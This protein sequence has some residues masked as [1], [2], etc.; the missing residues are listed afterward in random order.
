MKFSRVAVQ[1]IDGEETRVVIVQP[2]NHRVIDAKK[3]YALALQR[4][5]A[6]VD[7]SRRVAHAT[8]NDMT[9]AISL[10]DF[11]RDAAEVALSAADDASSPLEEAVFRAAIKP[12]VIRD[13]LT[14]NGHIKSFFGN[15][16]KKTP[17][18][19]VYER[20]GYFKG[21]TSTIFGT[22]ETI[23]FPSM[24]EKLDY[25]LEIGYIISKFG[26]SIEPENAF[27]HLFGL[28]IFNDWSLRDVQAL[29]SPIGM[30]AQ[31]AKDF[32]YGIGPWIVTMDEIPSIIG[33]QGQVRVNG[34]IRSNTKVE[35]FIWTPQET[36]AY[37]SQ[38][39]GLQ[40]GDI[41][42]SGTMALGSGVEINHYLEPGDVLELEL[43][44]VGVLRSP[45]SPVKEAPS[46]W[47]S[48]QPFPFE[49]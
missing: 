3:A 37:A 15:V 5:G 20:P 9:E 24:T 47:P 1:G 12:P 44:K 13:S 48:P 6:L 31:H 25:E 39:N 21:T 4:R 19:E 30:G 46:W 8:F 11:M 28:T 42:G 23:P 38:L 16:L 29:E 32:A 35:D 26:R 22:N 36:I 33:L 10:G 17:A 18:R 49:V 45:I 27:D 40:P 2:E 14:F 41:I 34:E 43:E 7:S